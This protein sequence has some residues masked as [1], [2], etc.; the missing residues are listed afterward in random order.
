MIS[1]KSKAKHYLFFI[2]WASWIAICGSNLIDGAN[3]E[4]ALADLANE[5]LGVRDMQVSGS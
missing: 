2:A 5:G 3:F 1:F 4:K